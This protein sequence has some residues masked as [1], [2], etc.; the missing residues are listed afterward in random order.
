MAGRRTVTSV[1]K[2]DEAA[3]IE[4]LARMMAGGAVTP[5]T[6][7]SAAELLASKGAKGEGQAKGESETRKAKAKRTV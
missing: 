5:A 6:I 2:L 3:R 4:E 1:R 7:A